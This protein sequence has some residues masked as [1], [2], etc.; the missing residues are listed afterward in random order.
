MKKNLSILILFFAVIQVTGQTSLTFQVNLKDL[1]KQGLF[2]DKLGDELYIR[3][4]FNDWN[5]N[6]YKLERLK[7]SDLYT[8]TFNFGNIGDTISY[9]YIIIKNE[10][11]LFWESIPNP[12][13]TNNS[14]RQLIVDKESMVLPPARFYYDEYFIYP[15]IFSEKNLKKIFCNFEVF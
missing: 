15:I 2:S 1:I 5:G 11:R 4:S 9:K 6:N 13:I 8:G 7:D 3:G 12:D 10:N 14:N